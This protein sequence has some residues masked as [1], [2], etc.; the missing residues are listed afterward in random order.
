MQ[1]Y[2][3]VII[4]AGHNGL[5]CAAYLGMAGLKV[6]VLERRSVVGGAAVTE[7]FCPGFRNSVAA[8]TVSLLQPQGHRGSS[9]LPARTEA[10]SSAARRISCPTLDGQ[11]LLAAEGQTERNV[12]NSAAPM[13]TDTMPSTGSSTRA[14]MSCASSSCRRH[15]ISRAGLTLRAM[16]ELLKA[17]RL[18]NRLRRLSTRNLR[19]L[20]RS[21][22]QV[23]RRLSRRLVRRRPRQGLA[24]L[25]RRRRELRQSI[26]ARHRLRS[27]AS[28]IRRGERQKA[29]LGARHRRHGGDHAGDGRR[30]RGTWRRDRDR[31]A[32]PGG[33][34]R[35]GQG[36]AASCSRMDGVVRGTRDRCQRRIP[37]CFI[38]QWSRATRSIRIF[39]AACGDGAAAPARSGSTSR[40][41]SCRVLRRF[42]AASRRIITPPA[43]SL[44]RASATWIAPIVTR[45]PAGWSREPIIEMLIPSTLDDTLAP[46]GAHVASL[47]CQHVAPESAGWTLLERSSRGALP[48]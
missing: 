41:R 8:Y 27:P 31:R 46:P 22:H 45:G 19:A 14:P 20:S 5:T 24:R 26:Y 34:D 6:K 36:L 18:G 33:R 44:R 39:C 1:T 40:S 4:G 3:V 15:P 32:G 17:G 13:P 38:R 9:P 23:G 47:F 29:C 7:E 16:G 30:G 43:S 12:A 11:Y 25:R 35:E 2:D 37:G 28:R 42:R 48:I 10:L 21:V